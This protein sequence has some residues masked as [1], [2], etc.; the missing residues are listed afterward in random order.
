MNNKLQKIRQQLQQEGINA[1]II[2]STDPHQSEYIANHWKI[3]EW[4][5]GFTGSAGTLVITLED[6]YLWTDSRY[7]TQAETQLQGSGI[8]LM[9]LQKAH[10]PEHLYWL[11]KH[12]PIGAVI[13]YDGRLFSVAQLQQMQEVFE[14]KKT[15]LK[16]VGDLSAEIWQDRPPLPLHP[17][18]LHEL[19]Y[20]GKSSTDKLKE[21]RAFLDEQKADFQLL[22]SL[23]DIAWLFNIRGNDV[24]FNPVVYAFALVSTEK[25]VLF[26]DEQ[27]VTDTIAEQ[28]QDEGIELQPYNHI[29]LQL[30]ALPAKSTVLFDAQKT[31]AY[32][33]NAI[34]SSCTIRTLANHT[35]YL[36]AIKN[37]TEIE[38]W[39]KVMVKD[40]VALVK[41]YV[42]LDAQL[43][44]G[45]E[46][47]EWTAAERLHEFRAEQVEFIGDSFGAISA[48]R[49]SGASPHYNPSSTSN[50]M[51]QNSGLYLLDSGGQYLGGT[52]DITRTVCLGVPTA[53]EKRDFTLVLKGFIQ[54]SKVVFP[55]GTNGYQLE[56]LAKTA[57]WQYGLNYLHGTGHGVGFCLNVHEGPQSFGSG[58]T[59]DLSIAFEVGMVTTIEPAFY[60]EGNYGIRTENV[61]LTTNSVFQNFLQ[62]EALT[63]FPIAV[64][65]I[66]N[67]LL[68]SD[69]MAWL[70]TYHQKVW[71]GLSPYLNETEQN[72]LKWTMGY[73]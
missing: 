26:I 6:A 30:A 23:D 16:E 36:K 17:I 4:L 7:F 2:P 22:S 14:S 72:W 52:T 15:I 40:G 19:Q 65:L 45:K 55:I 50:K 47:N 59:A 44:E 49:S 35:T 5:S 42:W 39:R 71:N 20:C 27:K 54:L 41:F 12:L 10:T 1:Y 66:D 64:D 25:A 63:L 3:R 46:A 51:L 32:L 33:Q 37:K 57:L 73:E 38:N 67:R 58:A 24:A 29:Y 18:F 11:K 61:V 69:E 62:F 68:T 31:N 53:E 43:K 21:M 8:G 9:K 28:L 13:G 70:E 60:K 34:P 56:A 48:Y